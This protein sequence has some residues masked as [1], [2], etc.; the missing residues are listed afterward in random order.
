MLGCM[1]CCQCMLCRVD[2]EVLVPSCGGTH[3]CVVTGAKFTC[4]CDPFSCLVRGRDCSWIEVL[5][6]NLTM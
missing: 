6:M 4:I 5:E 1:P 3:D 2:S